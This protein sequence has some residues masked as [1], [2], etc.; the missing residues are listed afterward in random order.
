MTETATQPDELMNEER[1]LAWIDDKIPGRGEA[2]SVV[3]APGGASNIIFKLERAGQQYALRRP[4]KVA[5]DPTSNNMRREIGLLQALKATDI[6][7]PRLVAA[8]LDAEVIGAPFAVMEWVDGF[9]P[10]DP[11][12]AAFDAHPNARRE[13]SFALID[14]L[15][16]I[17]NLDWKAAGLGDFGKPERFLERQVDRWF[18]QLERY[19]SREIPGLAELGDWLRNNTPTMQRSG[20]M[21][22]DYQFVNVMFAPELPVRLAAV[23][24][25]ESA[26]IGD[27]PLDLGWVLAG[28]QEPGE[29]PTY[30][31]YLTW[32]G[33]PTRAELAERYAEK[34]GLSTEDLPYYMGLAVFKLAIIMEGA[35]HRYA[36]GKSTLI[37]HQRM[38]AAVPKMVQR[39]LRFVKRQSLRIAT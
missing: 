33:F 31:T 24:D 18:S 7:H 12:P 28:W 19:R 9:T 14:A 17:S 16:T 36:T 32:D 8:C 34:T 15:A 20:L 23:V 22:G 29:E 4:P 26:T 1:L 27:P 11:L 2:L 35:Y 25:W 30:A 38:E 13:M 3:R 37:N 6:P 21:H 39:G 10:R 5:N